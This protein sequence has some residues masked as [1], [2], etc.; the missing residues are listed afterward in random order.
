MSKSYVKR[1]MNGDATEERKKSP[2]RINKRPPQNHHFQDVDTAIRLKKSDRSEKSEVIVDKNK[3]QLVNEQLNEVKDISSSL[4]R[5]RSANTRRCISDSISVSAVNSELELHSSITRKPT[6]KTTY[7]L[8]P[9]VPTPIPSKHGVT[10]IR[11][12]IEDQ[13]NNLDK[14]ETQLGVGDNSDLGSSKASEKE[15]KCSNSV[16]PQK[17]EPVNRTMQG[18][19]GISPQ[20]ISSKDAKDVSDVSH[21]VNSEVSNSKSVES[22]VKSVQNVTKTEC[23][24]SVQNVGV[25]AD[26]VIKA[27]DSNKDIKGTNAVQVQ[28][29]AS[30]VQQG[31]E[32][33]AAV[34]LNKSHVV[35]NA[36]PTK[37]V[38]SEH[39]ANVKKKEDEV[40][41]AAGLNKS[42]AVTNA[43]PTKEVNSEHDANVKKKEDEVDAAAGLN[44]S[45]AVTNAHPTKEAESEHEAKAKKKEEDVRQPRMS[46]D[47]RFMKL[48]EE[49][50]RGAFKTV[51]KGLEIDTGVHVAWCE[52]QDKRWGKS[53]RKRF[54]EEAEMLKEL[55]HPNILRFFDYWEEEGSHRQKIIVLITELMTSGTL[56][57][58][59]GRFKKLNLKVLKNWCR[60]IL[61]GLLYLHTRTPPIIHRDLKCDNI[62]ITGTTGSVKIGDLGLATLKNNSFAKSVIGTPEFMAPEMY[63][64][65]YDEAVDVYAFG[66]CMLEMASSEYPYK[67]CHNPGQIYRKVTTGVYPEALDKVKDP[68]IHGIIE[69]CIRTKKEERLTVKDLLAHDFFLEDTGLLV[70]FLGIEDELADA[71]VIPLRL[72]VVDAKKRRDTHKENEAIQFEF[73]LSKDQPEEIAADLV[74]SG[75]LLDDDKRIVAKQIRDRIA[76]VL[77]SREKK[78]VPE[79]IPV[80]HHALQTPVPGQV[81]VAHHTIQT[82]QPPSST[83]VPQISQVATQLH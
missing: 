46:P 3:K 25:K 73:D 8:T 81:P 51:H 49:V 26:T 66:M 32:D 23:N 50:G 17:L 38:D 60:Q 52:L 13:S 20:G 65:H 69:G 27:S 43:Q 14:K 64:E 74:K 28:G 56:K 62:F 47:H 40:D 70:E 41:A 53:D 36:Q 4:V 18:S 48:D 2:S 80:Q 55:Q 30:G 54:K 75:F 7:K 39:D 45:H 1:A 31:K 83:S 33:D 11:A 42:H 82:S 67:E 24:A 68:E 79:V 57:T 78:P 29:E 63:E 77:K 34:G 61:K 37:E 76:Q 21:N 6:G 58:Y 12:S 15:R 35:I 22:N 59:L 44:K 19:K 16:S 9:L 71:Q 10:A 72:R 5:P